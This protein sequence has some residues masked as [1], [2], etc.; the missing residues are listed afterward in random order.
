[1]SKEI[2]R[3]NDPVTDLKII[4]E[5]LSREITIENDLATHSKSVIRYPLLF[6]ERIHTMVFNQTLLNLLDKANEGYYL[7]VYM[8]DHLGNI[9]FWAEGYV[10]IHFIN[11][12]K[13]YSHN[14]KYFESKGN[15]KEIPLDKIL[16]FSEIS[17]GILLDVHSEVIPYKTLVEETSKLENNVNIYEFYKDLAKEFKDSNDSKEIEEN[18][19]IFNLNNKVIEAPPIQQIPIPPPVEVEQPVTKPTN[20]VRE[21]VMLDGGESQNNNINSAILSRFNLGA[22]VENPSE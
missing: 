19:D 1:M 17:K 20:S 12:L 15:E 5:K 21:T 14:Y 4:G 3:I 8:E 16:D 10:D 7:P 22:K 2:N 13:K 6:L 11:A 18:K 9:S